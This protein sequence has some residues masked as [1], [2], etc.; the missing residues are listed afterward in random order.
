MKNRNYKKLIRKSHRYLGVFIGI[1]L[2]FLTISGLYFSWTE[3]DEIRGDHLRHQDTGLKML[4]GT[5]PPAEIYDK[6]LKIEPD[7]KISSFRIVSVLDKNFYEVIYE[8][9]DQKEHA[10]LFEPKTGEPRNPVRQEEAEII[11]KNAL[12]QKD[13]V[14]ETVYL[15]KETELGSHH[16]YREKQLPAW[17]VT[18]D[19]PEA[20]TV[21]V[22]A[23]NGQV[24]SFRTRSWRVFDFLWMLHTMDFLTRDNFNNWFLR[25][26]AALAFLII[27]SGFLY[28]FM[29]ARRPSANAFFRRKT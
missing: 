5:I 12:D 15:S 11:A 20:L 3:I 19:H 9:A 10:A 22:S 17:A 24:Q 26:I 8:T 25:I 2:L 28:F 21:Y 14:R 27:V 23:E 16:E 6:L 1:Q 7:A 29:S 4:E 18:F 13:D